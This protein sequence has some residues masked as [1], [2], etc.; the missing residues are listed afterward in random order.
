MRTIHSRNASI[1]T[2]VLALTLLAAEPAAA[3][4][5]SASCV[6]VT[7][8]VGEY[9][10]ENTDGQ[11][12]IIA[13]D[14]GRLLV[15]GTPRLPSK[16]Y[17]I[18]IPPGTEVTG[19]D[20]ETGDGIVLPGRY[21]IR[22]APL[23]RVIGD[24]NPAVHEREQQQYE[25]NYRAVFGSDE[26][27]P[28]AA[29]EFVRTAGYRKYSLVDVRVTPFSYRPVSKQLT[30]YPEI[31]VKVGYRL[32]E[33]SGEPTVDSLSRTEHVARDI[34]INYDEAQAWHPGAGRTE[35]GLHDFVII[36]LE[37]LTSA[38]APLVTWETIKGRTVEVVTTNWIST[39]YSGYDLAEKMR[40]F[41]REKYPSM[42]WGIEDVLM[43]GHYDDVPMRRT[44]QDTGYG[45]PET[46]FYYA[47]LSLPDDESWDADGDHN[48]GEDS[49]PIDFYAEVNV[50]RIPWS[51]PVTVQHICE[52]SVAYEENDDP[53]FKKNILLLGGYFWADTDNAVMMEAKVDQLWMADW[54]MT[55]MYEQN[56]SYWSDYECDY[57]LLH[58]N[59]MAVWPENTYCFVNW[60]GHGSPTSCHIYGLGAPAF[61][62][63]SD[64]PQLNDDYPAIIFADACSNSDTDD[65]NIGQAML[66]QGGVGFVGATKVAYGCHAWDSPDDGSSQSLDYLFT[67]YVTSEQYTQGAALQEALREMYVN[68]YWYYDRYETFEWG[69]LWGNPNL[70]V[71]APPVLSILFPSG[72]PEVLP[73]E[74]PT[75]IVV[76]VYEGGEEYVPGSA[77][78]HTM[79]DD[80]DVYE[81]SP[82]EPLGEGM[83]LATLPAPTC[84]DAPK[85]YFTVEGTQSGTVYQPLDGA[86]APFAADVGEVIV[87]MDD[88]FESDQGW[89]VENFDMTS[90][91][92]E[93]GIPV[94]G[95]ERQDPPSDYDGSGQC[96]LTG[97][98]AGNS[99]V[100]GGPTRLI[101]PTFDL[102]NT[103]NPI[104]RY[105]RW[106]LND[107]HDDDPLDVEVSND[108]GDSWVLI[109]R[110]VDE[111]ENP[112]TGWVHRKIY[113][114]GYIT[115]TALVKIRFCAMD[116]PNNSINEGGID[117]V[118]IE[119]IFCGQIACAQTGDLNNDAAV[120]GDDISAFASCYINGE[121]GTS[122]C[123]CA[124]INSDGDFTA[125]D[126]S[127]FVTCLLEGECPLG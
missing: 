37:S 127:A 114:S 122:E 66:E 95:G 79:Y 70:G 43:V 62:S 45:K 46:D 6:A 40:N 61:I 10:I 94:G 52:K 86:Q 11:H 24:E 125:D 5:D 103:T 101:S 19:V 58:D 89:V 53:A 48:W 118:T 23:P 56:S 1:T 38:V 7:I 73:P 119:D 63:S 36:T 41:L 17:A 102:S 18:A 72:V 68:G 104:L 85:F 67:T 44:W 100:D 115:P 47:E 33:R 99:D 88:N 42:A 117:A 35:R 80:G 111:E 50:G 109:E 87:H 3:S 27:Y 121:P 84:A 126:V 83:Y 22:P 97:N 98:V 69:A 49:D 96:Y 13:E 74:E 108:N 71:G 51:D 113:L 20:Y 106:W 34:I 90:G 120:N 4:D 28:Q 91:A 57:P 2:A 30:Y 21:D 39:N 12:E 107:D 9:Q 54:T 116:N 16:I 55:R 82:L 78:I 81:T 110:V 64:C 59:V 26:P 123:V 76:E 92:W 124:D 60:A 15:P 31:T 29:A 65:L 32:L 112:A 25:D 93:R 77:M 14:L 8:R 75:E 105:A